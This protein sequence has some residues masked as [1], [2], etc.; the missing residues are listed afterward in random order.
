MGLGRA[1]SAHW[2]MPRRLA[3]GRAG[4]VFRSCGSRRSIAAVA[5]RW[6]VAIVLGDPAGAR[7]SGLWR[8]KRDVAREMRDRTGGAVVVVGAPGS[9]LIARLGVWLDSGESPVSAYTD[10]RA[11]AEAAARVAREVTGQHG[12]AARVSVECW[13]PAQRRW[14]DASAVSQR[15]LAEER[16]YQQREDR[17]LSA[18]TGVAQWRVRIELRSHRDTVAL[19][20]R[21]SSDG[22]QVEQ[23][24]KAV[25]A[26]A[27]SED[28]AHRLAEKTRQYAPADAEVH[29]ERADTP[30]WSSGPFVPPGGGPLI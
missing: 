30:D 27:D 4:A 13:R 28:D 9:G 23:G 16:D 11:A 18:E 2:V 29:A 22:H 14:E 3:A 10:N 12:L 8:C 26:G 1:Q 7:R 21:L 20:Q 6:R 25:V 15:D 17:R 5:E 19:A 24:W